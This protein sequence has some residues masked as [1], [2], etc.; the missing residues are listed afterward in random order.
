M[1]WKTIDTAPKDGTQVLL[2]SISPDDDGGYGVRHGFY[3][4]G[5]ADRCWYDI[6]G[7]RIE[8]THWMTLPAAPE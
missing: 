2:C 6:G 5:M 7:E 8:P 1:Q 3:E 4:T